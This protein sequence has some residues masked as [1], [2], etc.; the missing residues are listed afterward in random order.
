MAPLVLKFDFEA[1][2]CVLATPGTKFYIIWMEIFVLVPS[3]VLWGR[4]D[5]ENVRYSYLEE[6]TGLTC[7]Y[8]P[9]TLAKIIT[10]RVK[11]STGSIYVNDNI[12]QPAEYDSSLII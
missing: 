2:L 10:G 9:A 6:W 8:E 5:L 4:R 3:L 12:A 11:P 7:I 1:F